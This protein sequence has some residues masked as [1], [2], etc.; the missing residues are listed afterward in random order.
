MA[1]KEKAICEPSM[2][3]ASQRQ[4]DILLPQ[5]ALHPEAEPEAG[6]HHDPSKAKVKGVLLQP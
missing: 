4:V 6:D 5:Y 3:A 1:L 2:E